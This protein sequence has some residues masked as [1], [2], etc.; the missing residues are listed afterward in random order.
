MA[1][2]ASWVGMAAVLGGAALAISVSS[3]WAMTVP[4]IEHAATLKECGACHMVYPP[5]MLPQ[6][7][8]DAMMSHLESHF[9]DIATVD[10]ATR[11]DILAFLLANAADA[12]GAPANPHVLRGVGADA[13]PE[14]ITALSW[15]KGRHEEV[16]FS[17]LKATKVKSASNCLGCHAGADKGEFHE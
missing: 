15:W 7:S 1:A 12:P 9:G 11:I 8:W 2:K 6:R 4:K 16:N 5:Q 14:R 13:V 3:T 10:E 17:N